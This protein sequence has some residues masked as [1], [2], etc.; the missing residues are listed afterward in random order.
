MTPAE[1]P[2]DEDALQEC[3]LRCRMLAEQTCQLADDAEYPWVI[4][5]YLKIALRLVACATA[6]E[7][8]VAYVWPDPDD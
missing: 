6:A 7:R 8:G 3:A 1:P 5:Q 2:P 4:S